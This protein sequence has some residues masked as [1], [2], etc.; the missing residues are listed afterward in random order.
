MFQFTCRSRLS[1]AVFAIVAGCLITPVCA[2]VVLSDGTF[3]EADWVVMNAVVNSGSGN[4]TTFAT[5]GNPGAYRYTS[6][7][8][9]NAP[10]GQRSVLVVANI[11]NGFVYDP[12]VS[13]AVTALHYSES[14]R[15]ES[16]GGAVGMGVAI[17]QAGQ[18]YLR[19]YTVNNISS[20]QTLSDTITADDFV[21]FDPTDTLLG[22]DASGKPDFSVNGAPFEIG[23]FR[24]NSTS[25]GGAGYIRTYA[26][27]NWSVTI[28]PGPGSSALLGLSGLLSAR[29]RR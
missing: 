2:D 28:V 3:N 22:E 6:I 14:Y 4:A 15:V 23:F 8:L 29:R 5:G 21:R 20:W 10:A 9:G 11:R 16:G 17:R 27:D 18:L 24:R 26:T 12:A 1:D 7:S 13:G 19:A 25:I